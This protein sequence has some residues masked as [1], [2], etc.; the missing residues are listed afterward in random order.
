[1]SPL[2]RIFI[3]ALF[4]TC[5]SVLQTDCA[6]LPVDGA[7]SPLPTATVVVGA[8][9]GVLGILALIVFITLGIGKPEVPM[10]VKIAIC[11]AKV[12][13]CCRCCCPSTPGV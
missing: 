8:I 6:P 9:V 13:P 11:W 2:R 7:L 12:C 1:M 4:I 5:F 10:K 3:F